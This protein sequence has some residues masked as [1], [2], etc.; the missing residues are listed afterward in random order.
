MSD[1]PDDV[2]AP[3][4]G[5]L[6]DL[7][8][9]H[10]LLGNQLADGRANYLSQCVSILVEWRTGKNVEIDRKLMDSLC[11]GIRISCRTAEIEP[12]QLAAMLRTL[13]S[14]RVPASLIANLLRINCPPIGLRG[15]SL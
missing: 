15:E 3:A 1:E 7:R 2:D 4:D 8:A 14:F 9:K 13:R 5:S 11:E 12:D 6:A 10:E